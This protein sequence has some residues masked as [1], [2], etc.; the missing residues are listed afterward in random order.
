MWSRDSMGRVLTY[1]IEEEPSKALMGMR[2]RGIDHHVVFDG[3]DYEG[4]F[5]KRY[6]ETRLE[7]R[8]LYTIDEGLLSVVLTDVPEDCDHDDVEYMFEKMVGPSGGI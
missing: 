7:L 1:Q 4:E 6:P 8:G 5:C 2:L 3:N